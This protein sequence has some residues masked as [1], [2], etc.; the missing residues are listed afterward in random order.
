MATAQKP[1]VLVGQNMRTARTKR[2]QDRQAHLKT[3]AE[4]HLPIMVL[5][6][7]KGAVDERL[8]T[9]VGTYWGPISTPMV[10]NLVA[11]SDLVIVLGPVWNDYVT[12]GYTLSLDPNK[13]VVVGAGGE[14]LGTRRVQMPHGR[15][16]AG[17]SLVAFLGGLAAITNDAG[18]SLEA[19]ATWQ[20]LSSHNQWYA[21]DDLP[22]YALPYCF[23][24]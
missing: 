22:R 11:A 9:F 6:S 17:V 21:I 5:P 18:V 10:S 2:Q 19:S 20:R 23:T 14:I 3:L 12:C 15:E 1:T 13:T 8:S 24:G 7:A 4:N 16:Y